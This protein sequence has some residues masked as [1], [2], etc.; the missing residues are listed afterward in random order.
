[1]ERDPDSRTPTPDPAASEQAASDNPASDP[2][3][4]AGLRPIPSRPEGSPAPWPANDISGERPDGIPIEVRIGDSDRP[5]LVAFL[6]T[7][8]DGCGDYWRGLADERTEGTNGDPALDPKA[9]TDVVAALAGV[10]PVIV[11]RGPGFQEP[12][13]VAAVA[14]GV[15]C[16]PVVMSDQAWRDYRVTSYPFFVLVDPRSRRII[17][18]T[19]GFGW[20]DVV[21]MIEAQGY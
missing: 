3:F 14:A 4:V 17:G 7:H 18:E 19:V 13:D 2:A 12:A 8:C 16:T 6:A 11:T 9:A 21:A 10:V 5:I 1:M 20:T 15:R